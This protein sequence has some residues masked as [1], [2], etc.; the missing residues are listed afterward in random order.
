MRIGGTLCTSQYSNVMVAGLGGTVHVTS[1]SSLSSSLSS[2]SSSFPYRRCQT[3][4]HF[5]V[6]PAICIATIEF[7]HRHHHYH[8]LSPSS[9]SRPKVPHVKSAISPHEVA[10]KLSEELLPLRADI[11]L[12]RP[13]QQLFCAVVMD[14]SATCNAVQQERHLFLRQLLTDAA[15]RH[16]VLARLHRHNDH[17][18]AWSSPDDD[19]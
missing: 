18:S 12:N 9:F 1:L 14:G 3:L 19:R 11:M 15:Y 5:L 13:S 17:T 7:H 10:P 4:C 8:E 6:S 16:Q 2:S